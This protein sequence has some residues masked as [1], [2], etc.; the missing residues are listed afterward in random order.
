M[1][2]A[3]AW[4]PTIIQDTEITRLSVDLEGQG[5]LGL[6]YDRCTADFFR[7]SWFLQLRRTGRKKQLTR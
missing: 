1:Q 6:G 3:A 4:E 7:I 2:E 5:H